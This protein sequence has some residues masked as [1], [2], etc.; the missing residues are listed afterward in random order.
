MR[1]GNTS[2]AK[3]NRAVNGEG[4]THSYGKEVTATKEN[5]LHTT[6]AE[7]NY[8]KSRTCYKTKQKQKQT[9]WKTELK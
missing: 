2:N 6:V 4:E 9:Q 5:T 8:F 7:T 1:N 3:V